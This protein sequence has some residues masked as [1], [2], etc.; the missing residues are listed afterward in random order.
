MSFEQAQQRYFESE[1]IRPSSRWLDLTLPT[2]RGTQTVR[3]HV[4]EMG[5]GPPVLLIH[6]G[7]GLAAAWASLMARLTGCRLVAPDRPGGGSSDGFDYRGVDLREHAV[8]WVHG[9]FDGLGLESALI[10]ANS[11]GARWATWFALEHPTRVAGIA[12]LGTPALL[13]DTSAPVPLRLLG[14]PLLGR[15]MMAVERPSPS[16]AQTLWKRMGHDPRQM[17]PELIDVVIALGRQPAYSSTFRTL[18][19]ACLRL[20]G[21]QPGM[22]LD[23]AQLGTLSMPMT[24]AVGSGDPF[25]SVATARRAATFAPDAAF[26]LAGVGHLPWFDEPVRYAEIVK[27][28]L[29]RTN[30]C[31][32]AHAGGAASA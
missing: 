22:S 21:A 4:L 2:R 17:S 7:G 5:H 8:R 23:E 12:A 18:L 20:G 6:G 24:I 25:G 10:V 3:T 13:L 27:A 26:E 29:A 30:L 32:L 28:L 9:I 19:G 1:G 31:T 11:M 15:L 14:R 16:Q